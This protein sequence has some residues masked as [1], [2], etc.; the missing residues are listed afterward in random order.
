MPDQDIGVFLFNEGIERFLRAHLFRVNKA[1][2]IMSLALMFSCFNMKPAAAAILAL[3]I[4]IIDRILEDIPYFHDIR[5][6]FIDYHLNMWQIFF[7]QHIAWWQI[8]ESIGMLFG[9]SL[10]FLIVG[11]AVFH[12]RDIKS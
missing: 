5:Q 2:A 1:T 12:V 6:Y 7:Q 10:T 3:S 11:V 8:G 9:F 4:F